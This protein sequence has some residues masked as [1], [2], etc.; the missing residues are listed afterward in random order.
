MRRTTQWYSM[1]ALALV[2][3]GLFV[4]TETNAKPTQKLE[5]LG[6]AWWQWVLSIPTDENPLF[7]ETGANCDVGQSGHVWNL[8]GVLNATGTVIRACTIPV[9]TKLFFPVINAEA[10][11]FVCIQDLLGVP[12]L[13]CSE[14]DLRYMVQ[15]SIDSVVGVEVTIDGVPV[16][17]EDIL[18]VQT[19]A[20]SF[21][22]PENNVL[23]NFCADAAPGTYTGAVS[24]GYWVLLPPFSVGEHTVQFAGQSPVPVIVQPE[25]VPSCEMPGPLEFPSASPNI[26][27][28]IT[29]TPTGVGVG[30]R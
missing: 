6:A 22:L 24:D 20:F 15:K 4:S 13:H 16:A 3:V 12:D 29:V 9:G 19:P 10:D 8:A 7:D 2:A 23:Q 17:A 14:E 28:N 18:R 5:S 11:N 25:E 26:T 27:Y 21:T 1:S 30:P